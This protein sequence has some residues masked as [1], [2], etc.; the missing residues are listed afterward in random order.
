MEKE[1]IVFNVGLCSGRHEMPV[2][3]YIFQEVET[4][5]M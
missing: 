4:H 2:S 1:K 3:E 5:V